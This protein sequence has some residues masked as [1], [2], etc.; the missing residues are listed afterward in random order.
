MK[1]RPFAIRL[2]AVV[3]FLGWQGR[4]DAAPDGGADVATED[5]TSADGSAADA[6]EPK[7]TGTSQETSVSDTGSADTGQPS[8][9]G[10][11][12]GDL[13]DVI[14]AD[15]GDVT[16]SGPLG[17]T[18]SAP[19]PDAPEA[20][21]EYG[22]GSAGGCSISPFREDLPWIGGG[23]LISVALVEWARGRRSRRPSRRW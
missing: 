15:G 12:A 21:A 20:G 8:D 3:T 22:T 1:T 9:S 19:L 10:A 6:A 17:Q 18:D 13:G 16:D 4:A 11:D 23:M 2:V 7:D 14:V 5:A